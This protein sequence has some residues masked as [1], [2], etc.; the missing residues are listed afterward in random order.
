M[1]IGAN[2]TKLLLKIN[3]NYKFKCQLNNNNFMNKYKNRFKK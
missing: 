3:N 2:Q 1:K